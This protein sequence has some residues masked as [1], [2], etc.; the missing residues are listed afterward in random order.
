M[1]ENLIIP[2]STSI[3]KTIYDLNEFNNVVD[4]S[5]SELAV[6]T[7]PDDV[8]VQPD[9]NVDQFFIEYDN[10]YYQIPPTGSVQSHL[11]LAGRSL[12]AVGISLDDLQSEIEILRTENIDLKN[13]ILVLSQ[14]N[15]GTL[16]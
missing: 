12:E 15:L 10:L 5:F 13:Q 16:A 6:T 1:D 11:E 2:D 3:A 8:N 7:N 4:T 9:L 14:T